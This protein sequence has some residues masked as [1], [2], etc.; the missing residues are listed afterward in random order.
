MGSVVKKYNSYAKINLFL[1][2]LDKRNDG[3]HNLQ[4]WFVFV[5]LKDK[6]TFSFNDSGIINISSN[7]DISQIED[8]L[9]YKAIRG[10]ANTYGIESVGVDIYIDKNIPMGAGLGGGSS[11]AAVALLAM[12]DFYRLN[13][14][15][16]DMLVLG[17]SLGADV[18]IFLHGKSAWA[19]G[20]GEIL[21]DKPYPEKYILL[22][23]PDIHIST[24]DFFSSPSLQKHSMK[25]SKD[26]ELDKQTMKNDFEEVF[27]ARYPEYKKIFDSTGLDFCM[28]GTGSCFF[29]LSENL[30]QLQKVAMKMDKGLDKWVLKTVNCVH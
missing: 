19:E 6:L 23:K 11:N 4:T 28:T 27:F 9:V 8:N 16:K 30:S 17:K 3:Y 18:P 2:V 26:S 14:Q 13:I 25:I 24:S 20:I 22:V 5:D 15:N 7:V 29:A 12:R 21:Y 1:H 10:F